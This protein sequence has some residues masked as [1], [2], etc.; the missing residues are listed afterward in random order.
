MD[1]PVGQCHCKR[2]WNSKREKHEDNIKTTEVW[3]LHAVT[4]CF[5]AGWD[6]Q[7]P[8]PGTWAVSKPRKNKKIRPPFAEG[9]IPTDTWKIAI[10]DSRLTLSHLEPRQYACA[11][12]SDHFCAFLMTASAV[13][14]LRPNG[15]N[16]QD[17][18]TS[19]PQP[20]VFHA[21]L[22]CSQT[23]LVFRFASALCFQGGNH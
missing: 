23:L 17:Q 21:T 18:N 7:R 4:V 15:H 2:V 19:L 9:S 6:R 20:L 1:Y 10:Q 12:P 22:P 8:S 3:A 16:R 13:T 11:V 14:H 5:E